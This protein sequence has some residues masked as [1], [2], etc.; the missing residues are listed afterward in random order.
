MLINLSLGLRVSELVALQWKDL[1]DSYP[2]IRRMEQKQWEQLPDGTWKAYL[3]VVDHTKSTAGTR[4]LYVVST[5]AALFEQVR[6]FNL[7]MGY[8]CEPDSYIFLHDNNRITANSIDSYYE[9]YCKMLGITKKGN[10]GA[11]RTALTK[12]ADNPNINL[13]D[14]MQWAGHRDVKTFIDHYCYSRYSD[15]QKKAKLEKTLNL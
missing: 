3:T 1:K 10:H 9:R 6:A 12:I 14:A 13:K 11:R 15:E 5:S 8:D 4:T 2:Q 7:R